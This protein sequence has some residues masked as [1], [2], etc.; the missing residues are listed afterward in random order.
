MELKFDNVGL[1][2]NFLTDEEVK[3]LYHFFINKRY[4][5]NHT[6]LDTQQP[7]VCK[8]TAYYLT[9][10]DLEHPTVSK[11]IKGI[12]RPFMRAYVQAYTPSTVPFPHK[13]VGMYTSVTFFHP[14]YDETWGGDTILYDER[15]LGIALQPT[16]GR[17]IAFPGGQ[18]KHVGRPFNSLASRFRFILIINYSE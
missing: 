13:D 15:G 16:P 10:E 12:D 17:L 14:K 11:V 5:I 1:I 2:D 6:S 7:S 18:I 3:G 8:Q 4:K 9:A